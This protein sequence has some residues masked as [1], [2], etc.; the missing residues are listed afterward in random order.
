VPSNFSSLTVTWFDET[1]SYTTS[2]NITNDVKSIP[3]FTDTGTGEVNTASLIIRSL[4]GNYNV[5]GSVIF[6]EFDRIRIQCTDLAGNSYDRFFEIFNIIPSQTK[7]EGTLLTI[8]CLG[9]EYHTQQIHMTKPYY[10]E[11]SYTVGAS[12]G[13]IYN[14]NRGTK[15]P[16]LEDHN[17]VY[18]N[19]NGFGNGLPF[20]NANN[21]DFAVNEDS[22]YNRW[23]DLIDN[24]GQAV[25]AGGALTFFELNFLTPLINKIQLKLRASGDNPTIK[26]IKNSVI[27]GVKV[28]EQEGMLSNPTGTNVMAW[29]SNDHGT[30]PV[31]H[32][33]YNSH[34]ER[35]IFRPEWSSSV[36][37]S[38]DARVKVTPTTEV[39]PKHYKALRE[40]QGDTPSTSTS[41]WEQID[42]GDEFGDTVQYSP[43]TD[44]KATLW[45]NSGC[46]P[47]K[48]TFTTGGWIDINCVINE[49][50]WFR[51]WVDA[52]AT[53]NSDL[54]TLATKYS[55]VSNDRNKFPRGFR[56]LVKTNSPS[57]AL[58]NFANMVVEV[59]PTNS[60][61]GVRWQKLYAFEKLNTKVQVAVI[62][63]GKVYT[64][65]ISGTTSSPIHTWSDL[66]SQG[67]GND[68]FHPYTTVP[69]NTDGV[70][71]VD[72]ITNE[73]LITRSKLVDV[74]NRPD[75]TKSGTD[76]FDQNIDSAVAFTADHAGITKSA[77]EGAA[78]PTSNYYKHAIGF[79]IRFPFPCNIDN[80]ISEG[81]GDIYGG[82]VNNKYEP[83]TLDI[84]N[85]N[86]TSGGLQGFNHG[87]ESEDYG[88]I[89]AVA[90]WLKY[91]QQISGAELDDEHRFRAWF[92]DTKDNVVYQD[93]VLTHSNNWEDIRLPISGFRNYR[94]RKP[95]YGYSAI[96]ASIIPPKELEV[97]NIFEWR[98]IKMFG[99]QFQGV[100]DKFG[101]YDPG[102]NAI[103]GD[104]DSLTW[105]TL[106]GS[107][108]VLT[109]DGFR[110]IKPLLAT[111]GQNTDRNLE[112]DFLQ[113][114]D[115][116]NYHQLEGAAKSH[117]EIEKFKHKEFN[118]ESTGDE[119][120]DVPFGDSFYLENDN[121]VSESEGG[122]S[123]NIK[124]V[125]KR[126]EYSITKPMGGKGGLRRKIKGSK[127]FT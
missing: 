119:I 64:D 108:K 125:A 90:M 89:S 83:A 4:D 24:G 46:N 12:V 109:M 15:Q 42:M 39:A 69:T 45:L 87:Q 114:P 102:K 127:V 107:N 11:D 16:V 37:Y 124:L 26:Q 59:Y 6:A 55:Y 54:D 3:L 126:V 93:F 1:D 92:V 8:D 30:L 48:S 72:D 50:K 79:T 31:D 32:S 98:N 85:M 99:V 97:I 67:Y 113:F 14:S 104:G 91:S 5:T 40:T 100:Y 9:I 49:E 52:I 110:F 77:F 47:S 20:Y 43:W 56:V 66:S 78:N 73:A 57:G 60:V 29:G 19:S 118:I 62:D 105:S 2:S 65:T 121:L 68:C 122:N 33:K 84:Q 51:T 71:L 112:P 28:G 17:I 94:G 115:I 25:E 63:E 117:L 22:C 123:N 120:F 106:A 58:A 44:E 23:I 7:G 82:G 10:F 53:S 38:Q 21:W 27:T 75:I 96:I 116:T 34:V 76:D 111:S 18:L 101:R 36:T 74:T 95:I 103:G 88:Q 70:D 80:S 61:G 13:D 35:F 41:D 86:Y 81:V